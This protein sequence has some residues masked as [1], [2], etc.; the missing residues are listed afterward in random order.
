[1]SKIR[2]RDVLALPLTT[3]KVV[4]KNPDVPTQCEATLLI[5]KNDVGFF[6][7]DYSLAE[8]EVL[9][10]AL[11]TYDALADENE[12]LKQALRT[13]VASIE[14][15]NFE[16][17]LA[18]VEDLRQAVNKVT[19]EMSL[20][21]KNEALRKENER[22]REALKRQKTL[23]EIVSG[24]LNKMDESKGCVGFMNF[25]DPIGNIDAA[26]EGG[27]DIEEAQK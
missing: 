8:L 3:A 26:L 13:L 6:T 14:G 11:S 27:T 9:A 12:R 10:N 21:C 25:H 24:D 1:M 4:G 22:L 16:G 23:W 2:V 15:T 20:I 17:K 19:E 18:T 5:D 7:H